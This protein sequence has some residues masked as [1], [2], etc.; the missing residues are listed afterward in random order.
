MR[1]HLTGLWR[2]PEFLKLWAGQTTSAFGTMISTIALPLTAVLALDATPVEMGLLQAAALVPGFLVGLLAGV[3]VDRLRRRPIMLGADL[4]RA[5]LLG[6][7]P[8]A[9]ALG[10]LRIE[11]LYGVAFLAGVLTVFFDVSSQSFLPSLVRREEL[12]GG[13]S[14]LTASASVAEVAGFGFGG[15][16]VQALTAP[17]AVLVDAISF[18]LSALSLALIRTP[19]PTSTLTPE[20]PSAAREIGEGLRLVRDNPLLRAV[21]GAT[22][23]FSFFQY[24]LGAVFLLYVTRE[25][26]I[27]PVLQGVLYAIG[28]V[29]SFFGALLAGRAAARWGLGRTLFVTLLVSGLGNLCVG[30]AG[31]PIVVVLTF[32]VLAQLVGDGAETAY[33][34]NQVSLRQA[35]TPAQ[36]QG[37]MNASIRFV[38]WSAMLLGTLVGGL[39]GELIGLRATIF[40][41]AFGTTLA[42]LWVLLS[43]L[44]R[45]HGSPALM[46]EASLEAP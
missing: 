6:S 44:R 46:A 16:L 12:V 28:G 26:G 36:L 41:G 20:R 32:L 23:T 37:R 15:A 13:N 29:S 22:A 21:A 25:L 45:L 17:I 40:V 3:W 11:Q 43:P 5:A 42:A 30:L 8:A 39:L 35:I 2:H 19:E 9:A 1:G 7:V 27:E 18:L 38:G 24:M 4:G 34:V 14:T 33:T 10:L 31:G